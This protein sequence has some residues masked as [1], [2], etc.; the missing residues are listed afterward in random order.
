MS[1][2]AE[3]SSWIDT[4]SNHMP[5]LSKP[6]AR[7]LALWSL[8]IAVARTCGRRTVAYF[9]GELLGQRTA[10]VE[11]RLREWCY[12]AADKRGERR[13][14]VEVSTCFAPLL[15]WV[16]SLFQTNRIA[17][18]LDATQL[19]DRVVV[20]SVSVVYRGCGIP[21][22]WHVC[23]AHQKES[24]RP[25]WLR[26]LRQLR[27]A[28]PADWSVLVLT[29]RGLYAR[30]LFRR[31]VRL[32]WHPFMRINRNAKFRP[33]GQRNWL[34]LSD[35]VQQV[36]DHWRG[37]G[38]AFKDRSTGRLNCTLLAWW[39]EGHDEPWFIL[40]DLAPTACQV[41]WYGLRAWC[42]QGFKCLKRGGWQWQSTRMTDPARVARLWLA[43]AVATLWV[44]SVGGAQEDT[45]I[46][47]MPDLVQPSQSTASTSPRKRGKRG[48]RV[49]RRGMIH[50]LVSWIVNS[51]LPM[52][53]PLIPEPWPMIYI[54]TRDQP[55]DD[56]STILAQD[57]YP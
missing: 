36:G 23:A 44:V 17:L 50:L 13:R 51:T 57:T 38:V 20:L 48:I 56:I 55:G 12:D 45:L 4:V 26:M 43:M 27:P 22:A 11:Q 47:E 5:H 8:G 30:W 40:T 31:I 52:P 35:L 41:E 19:S 42:E 21:V 2:R 29:D 32:G 28:I 37:R 53:K 39:G 18:A 49:F 54:P 16:V 25:H 1:R 33:D 46:P 14:E 7:M 6:Q 3:L 9:L 10:T 34:N 24:W 15:T